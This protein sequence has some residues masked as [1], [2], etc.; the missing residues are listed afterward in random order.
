MHEVSSD[1]AAQKVF[2]M[3]MV[4]CLVFIL[5]SILFVLAH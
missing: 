2:H 4:G 5:A 1:A 3:T